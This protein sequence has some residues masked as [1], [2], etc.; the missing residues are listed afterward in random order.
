MG[1]I[2]ALETGDIDPSLDHILDYGVPMGSSCL[3][4]P[5][6]SSVN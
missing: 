3:S 4:N 5:V 1:E 2:L 6:S